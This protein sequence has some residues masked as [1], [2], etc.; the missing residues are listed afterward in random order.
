MTR[1]KHQTTAPQHKDHQQAHKP[2]VQHPNIMFFRSLLLLSL[3]FPWTTHGYASFLKCFV[4]LDETEVIM[5]R[6]VVPVKKSR[7]YVTIE[8]QTEN[9]DWT[10]DFQYSGSEPTTI[11]ARLQVP[12]ELE[13][14]PVQFVM[15][16]TEGAVFTTPKMCEGR[17]SFSLNYADPVTLQIS[18]EEGS[19]TLLAG[20]AAGHEAVT[21]TPKL[22][23]KRAAAPDEL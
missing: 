21:L 10:S 14:D 22:L 15:E 13:D 12:H 5:N 9:G 20:W 16:T 18:G 23:L 3:L 11:Q 7:E 6:Y 1:T 8:V 2:V 4:D 17:R 19:V